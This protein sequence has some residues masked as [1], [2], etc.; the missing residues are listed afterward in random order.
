MAGDVDEERV[1]P[2]ARM[3]RARLDAVQAD[4]VLGERAEHVI[5][6]TRLVVDGD[7]Q[8]GAV[9]ARGREQRTADHQEARGVVR[10][11][12][13]AGGHGLEAVDLARRLAGNGRRVVGMTRHTSRF[14]IAAYRD[15]LDV[16]QVDAQPGL[17]LLQR[18]RMRIDALDVLQLAAQRMQALVHA[19]LDFAADGGV[20]GEEHVQGHL[21]HA[22]PGVLHRHHAE[23]GMAGGDFLEH[24]LDAAQRQAVGGVAEV[25]AHGLLAERAF[26][27]EEAD[28]QR[29]FLGQAG[30]HDLAKQAHHLRI[31]QRAVVAVHHHAQHMRLALRA[32]VVDRGKTLALHARHCPAPIRRARR[33]AAGSAGRYCRCA[34]ARR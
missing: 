13:D 17:A 26:R 11:I 21:D 9:V 20:G 7:Q 25:L 28:L 16:R 34:R 19:Q 4:A 2:L 33:S 30:R 24:F 3:R 10:A 27:P 22:L 15:A 23:I 32:V 8:R 31:R 29:I 18:L 6:R 5:Q 14:G 12:L 1:L